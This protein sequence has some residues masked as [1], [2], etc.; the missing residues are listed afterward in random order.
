MNDLLWFLVIVG[1]GFGCWFLGAAWRDRRAARMEKDLKSRIEAQ[2]ILMQSYQQENA[3]L[4]RVGAPVGALRAIEETTN[5]YR[6]RL[7]DSEPGTKEKEFNR[8]AIHGL[9][10]ALLELRGWL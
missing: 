7:I 8:G 4:R 5:L 3:R 2:R 6:H 1:Y 10:A 9:N